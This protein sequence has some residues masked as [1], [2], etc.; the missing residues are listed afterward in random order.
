VA[1]A[2]LGFRVV[3]TLLFAGVL[4]A[5][6]H[7]A[8]QSPGASPTFE[9]A[10]VRPYAPGQIQDLAPIRQ[11]PG[12]R[13]LATSAALRDLVFYAYGLDVYQKVE[14]DDPILDERFDV[15]ARAADD[16]PREALGE[17]GPMRLMVQAL[18]AERFDLSV[19][20]EEREQ[21]VFSLVLARADGQPGSHLR[22][23]ACPPPGT[24]VPAPVPPSA[25][26][27]TPRCGGAFT[28]NGVMQAPGQT[29]ATFARSLSS[30]LDARVLDRTGLEGV[31]DVVDFSF[32]AGDL[33]RSR[34]LRG[35]LGGPGAATAVSPTADKPSLFTAL[36]Q[37]LGLKLESG[38]GPV[39][40]LIVEHV[41]PLI[42]N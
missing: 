2:G 21:P 31:F 15:E 41:E 35:R 4:L 9:V 28:N 22:P 39:P 40:V 42:E 7:A 30:M 27:G 24:V 36:Q 5:L 38:R 8:A 12:G 19:R 33:P 20:W 34:E 14:G 29:M 1:Q 23:S 6:P 37:D 3:T 17:V 13:F 26:P 32:D 25:P 18:L 11:M 10:S 16:L